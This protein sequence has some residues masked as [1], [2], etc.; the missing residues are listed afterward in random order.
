MQC[1][2]G[3]PALY[4]FLHNP[5]LFHDQAS[6]DFGCKPFASVRCYLQPITWKRCPCLPFTSVAC[7][8]APLPLTVDDKPRNLVP[9]TCP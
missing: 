1:K 4:P 3:A 9:V 6:S 2:A 5:L 8:L 7:Y